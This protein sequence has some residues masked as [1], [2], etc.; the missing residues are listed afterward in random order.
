MLAEERRSR[1]QD[2]LT[3]KSTVTISELAEAYGTSEMTIR[4]DLDELEARGVCQRIHGGAMSLRI[5][6]YRNNINYPDF[7]LREQVQV[8]EKIA[9]GRAAAALVSPGDTIVVDSGTTA[10]YMAHALRSHPGSLTVISNS[11][12]VLEQL[13]DITRIL[14][15]SPG[16]TLSVE[17]VGP[18]GDLS[19]V[20]PVT[21]AALRSFRPNKA[22]ITASGITQADGI[23]NLSLFQAE[24]KRTMIDIAVE[25]ILITDHTKFGHASGFIVAGVTS[26]SRIITDTLAPDGDVE[27]LR[28]LGIEV[29]LVEPAQDAAVLRPAI[30]SGIVSI[31][32]PGAGGSIMPAAE[33]A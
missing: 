32:R 19:F 26:F 4:R 20:G 18:G 29:T 5:L 22:F 7:S 3:L 9:I 33:P 10:A 6:E 1:I 27:A 11:L 14:L 12:R 2:L 13:Y 24:I 8:G 17:S 28:A 25:S 23:S 21:V 16:G 30:I 31:D 15:I